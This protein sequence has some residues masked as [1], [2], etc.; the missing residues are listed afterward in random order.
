[1]WM[2]LTFFASAKNGP[3][4]PDF[5]CPNVLVTWK[6][7]ATE[8]EKTKAGTQRL[9]IKQLVGGYGKPKMAT[10][11]FLASWQILFWF[12]PSFICHSAF[13]MTQ[14]G[15]VL[16]SPPANAADVDLIPGLGRFPGGGNGNPL[17]YSC[18]KNPMD[19]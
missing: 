10:W 5:C 19:R 16:K 1:M 15:T 12:L 14:G 9:Q 2:K 3:S 11:F 4:L 6:Q 8:S 7:S 18:L 13:R 17:Q